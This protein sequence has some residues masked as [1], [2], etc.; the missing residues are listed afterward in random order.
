[1]SRCTQ[2]EERQNVIQKVHN[3]ALLL[4]HIELGGGS[5]V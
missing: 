5:A 3:T 4:N 2:T 1:M